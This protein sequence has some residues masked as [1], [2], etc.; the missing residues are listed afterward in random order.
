MS[1]VWL[2]AAAALF[3]V[4]WL[5]MPGVGVTDAAQIFSLVSTQRSLVLTSVILQLASAVLYVPALVGTA[6]DRDG[7]AAK[8]IGWGARLLLVGA[9][10]SAADAVLHLLAYA[11]TAPELD[12]RT[13]VAVM[14]FMQGQGL[15][16]LTPLILSFFVGGAMLS[17]ALRNAGVVSS[18]NLGCHG[19]AVLVAIAGGA[20]A[21]GGIVSARLVGLTALGLVSGAQVWAGI[22]LAKRGSRVLRLSP[23]VA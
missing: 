3:W 23:T 8:A 7:T 5:L 18:W 11:M 13:I 12:M 17:F 14:T 22:A 6:S 9:M 2:A 1:G 20:L 16:L 19:L 21:S 10:G 15:V 4:S